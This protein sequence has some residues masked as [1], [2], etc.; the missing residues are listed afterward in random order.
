MRSI[1]SFTFR[2]IVKRNRDSTDILVR[3]VSRRKQFR[4]S[5]FCQPD[6]NQPSKPLEVSDRGEFGS[7]DADYR[8][9]FFLTAFF[10]FFGAV[11]A[12]HV[13]RQ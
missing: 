3:K 7:A 5:T 13:S 4:V 6:F 10:T 9:S 1:Q 8:L 12:S 2:I 11:A